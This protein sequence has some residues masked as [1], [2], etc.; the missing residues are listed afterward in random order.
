MSKYLK[1]A[2]VVA[3]VIAAA[4]Y[5]QAAF[6]FLPFYVFSDAEIDNILSQAVQYGAALGQMACSR[7]A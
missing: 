7:G 4:S 3:V 1:I 6:H 5:A 2:T